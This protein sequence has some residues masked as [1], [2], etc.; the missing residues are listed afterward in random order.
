MNE[1][2][3]PIEL[4]ASGHIKYWSLFS[5]CIDICNIIT[6]HLSLF[7]ILAPPSS[8]SLSPPHS[9]S[10][11]SL[12]LSPSPYFLSQCSSKSSTLPFSRMYLYFCPDSC[13]SVA[14]AAVAVFWSPL[15]HSLSGCHIP[16]HINCQNEKTH[17]SFEV[18][19]GFIAD[20]SDWFRGLDVSALCYL[21]VVYLSVTNNWQFKKHIKW[22]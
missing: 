3:T 4:S 13:F 12:P 16:P 8:L 19:C 11:P 18:T 1:C 6:V 22:L 14:P 2:S 15:H 10:P 21:H 20:V 7:H 17:S 5:W 9:H